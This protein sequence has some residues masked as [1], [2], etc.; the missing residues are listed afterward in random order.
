MSFMVFHIFLS[1]I[2]ITNQYFKMSLNHVKH[3]KIRS[4]KSKVA[5]KNYYLAENVI[6]SINISFGTLVKEVHWRKAKLA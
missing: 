3:I 5:K 6:I 2:T 1:Y 4:M